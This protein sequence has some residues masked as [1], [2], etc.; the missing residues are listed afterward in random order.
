MAQLFS[1]G[2][3]APHKIMFAKSDAEFDEMISD[4]IRRRAKIA[5]LTWRR[6]FI[7]ICAAVIATCAVLELWSGSKAAAAGVFSAA[8]AWSI[9]FKIES[10]LR[11]LRAIDRLQKGLDER[12]V[13]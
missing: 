10:D 6:T 2:H 1:L 7:F 5:S 9:C 3:F 12:P 11:L 13:A 4:P 8:V